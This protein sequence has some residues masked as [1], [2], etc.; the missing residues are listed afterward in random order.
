L[1]SAD[2]ELRYGK[3]AEMRKI[4]SDLI[5]DQ[6]AQIKQLQDWLAKDP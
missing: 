4:A 3:D 5:A 2:A 6:A 1:S